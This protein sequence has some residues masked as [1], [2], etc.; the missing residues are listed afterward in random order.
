MGSSLCILNIMSAVNYDLQVA[1]ELYWDIK[2]VTFKKNAYLDL[3]PLT[4]FFHSTALRLLFLKAK[5]N[6]VNF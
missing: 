2:K 3:F 6:F 5:M 4:V 1:F